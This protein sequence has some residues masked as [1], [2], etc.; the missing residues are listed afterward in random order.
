M[1]YKVQNCDLRKALDIRHTPAKARVQQ[2]EP[3]QLIWRASYWHLGAT[4]AWSHSS[5]YSN[6]GIGTKKLNLA[7]LDSEY[8]SIS[9]RRTTEFRYGSVGH[10]GLHKE[11]VDKLPNGG[12]EGQPNTAYSAR[13]LPSHQKSVQPAEVHVVSQGRDE[14]Q[15]KT[16][17]N[18]I[19]TQ[20][21]PN[22]GCTYGTKGDMENKKTRFPGKEM[23]RE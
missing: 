18:K 19:Q 8:R 11:P 3:L 4:S 21:R 17:F 1:A 6:P 14:V 5:F 22:T 15:I 16:T 13:S 9:A 23:K 20:H 7:T 2:E 12:R 10:G